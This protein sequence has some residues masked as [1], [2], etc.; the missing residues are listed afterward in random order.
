MNFVVILAT[1]FLGSSLTKA[2]TPFVI[3]KFNLNLFTSELTQQVPNFSEKLATDKTYD[4][5]N[6]ALFFLFSLS[7]F[8]INHFFLSRK[9]HLN[10]PITYSYLMFSLLIFLQS[11]FVFFSIKSTIILILTLQIIFLILSRIKNFKLSFIH[12]TE[13]LSGLFMGL[14]L[15]IFIKPHTSLIAIPLGLILTTPLVYIALRKLKFTKNPSHVI[16]I[17]ASLFPFNKFALILIFI[18]FVYSLNKKAIKASLRR[19]YPFAALFIF[20]YNPNFYI[21]TFDTIEEGFWLAWLERLLK[22]EILYKDFYAYHPPLILWG[23]RVFTRLTEYSIYH[24]RLYLHILEIIGIFLIYQVLRK[25]IN[26]NTLRIAALI[27]IFTILSTELKN[28]VEIR[29]GLGLLA[30]LP[31]FYYIKFK[32]PKLLIFAGFLSSISLLTSLEIGVVSFLS[33]VTSIIILSRIL[34]LK[35][36]NSLL[37]FLFGACIP[38]SAAAVFLKLNSSL[39]D[40]LI[41]MKYT[42]TIFSNGYRNVAIPQTEQSTLLEWFKVH[43]FLSSTS[44]IWEIA[45]FT[46]LG[47]ALLS[48]KYILNKTKDIQTLYIGVL[49]VF[50]IFLLRPL[51]GRSDY[52]HLITLLI[53]TVIILFH[54][55]ERINSRV[56]TAS[57]FLFLAMV[58]F[59]SQTSQLLQNQFTKFQIYGT[60]GGQYPGYEN[61]RYQILAG[62]EVDTKSEDTLI[63]YIKDNTGSEDTIFIFPQKAEIYFLTDRLNATSYDTPFLYFTETY[64]NNMVN[65]LKN[66]KPKLII[67]NPNITYSGLNANSLS[68]VKN[69]IEEN[70]TPKES[71]GDWFILE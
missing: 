32:S 2:L 22:G 41:Q 25:L 45:K 47:S 5:L 48:I 53:P 33:S 58:T 31:I 71:L 62:I 51:L 66:N 70:Y 65:E 27:L 11:H 43:T 54:Y 28:N 14:Y 12:T 8:L 56:I 37:N 36:T 44:W 29:L 46:V 24:F 60:P 17:L 38:I 35:T 68:L 40:F 4:V 15:S 9:R 42:T 49:T 6:L 26:K 63:N 16:L 59:N 20:A 52:Y 3:T 13:A 69:Y 21:G 30:T 23:L 10:K 18:F 64:Q 19:L 1:L 34:K 39:N 57:A 67:Y 50:C 55:L 61:S 7:I